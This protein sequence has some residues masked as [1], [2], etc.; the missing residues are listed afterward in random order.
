M[1]DAGDRGRAPP[2]GIVATCGWMLAAFL[3]ALAAAAIAY[4]LWFGPGATPATQ[5][6]DGVGLAVASF[7]MFPL[8]V[9]ILAMA[10]RWRGWSAADYFALNVPRRGE[11][12]MAAACTLALIFAVNGLLYLTG[13]DIVSPFQVEAYRTAKDAGWLVWTML[14]IVVVAPVGE[15]IAFRGFMYRGLARPG[16]EIP[17]IMVIALVWSLL[18]IQ[19]DWVGM[20][21]IFAI[22]LLFGWFRWASGST[23]LTILMHVLVNLESMI[24][25]AIKVEMSS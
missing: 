24:E 1:T 11:V 18:H 8:E 13:K 5:P 10:A 9:A 19:Y 17:A 16:S 25:T 14:A 22:G 15:E 3:L 4:A 12:V 23:T 7:V 20:L 6:Y 2:W 21:Q